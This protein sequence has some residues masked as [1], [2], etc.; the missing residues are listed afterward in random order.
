LYG[1]WVIVFVHKKNS[2][3]R[4]I[5]P[6]LIALQWQKLKKEKKEK[7]MRDRIKFGPKL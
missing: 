3:A 6:A 4:A 2:I 7:K 1:L 5:D